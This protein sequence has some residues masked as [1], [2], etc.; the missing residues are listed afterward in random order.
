MQQIHARFVSHMCN[1]NDFTL[2]ECRHFHII[3]QVHQPA[4]LQDIA[5]YLCFMRM[6]LD[7]SVGT[8]II[9]LNVDH[10]WTKMRQ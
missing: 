10:L 2:A 7:M 8:V 1:E 9:Y 5:S 6:L 4:Y 3:V